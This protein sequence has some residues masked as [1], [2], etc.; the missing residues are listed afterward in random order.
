MNKQQRK[1]Y[2]K[3]LLS[4]EAFVPNTYV[5]ACVAEYGE[6]TYYLACDSP[7][8][9]A[10][11]HQHRDNGCKDAKAYTV[12]IN[13]EGHITGINENSTNWGNHDAFD[14][15]VQTNNGYVDAS[16]VKIELNGIYNLQWKTTWYGQTLSHYGD[17]RRS[18]PINV[19]MS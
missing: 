11:G 7:L 13:Q 5:A 3:P 4:S 1:T 18:T 16:V 14:I 15:K 17:F 10:D 9:G 6:T 8:N 12:Y 2:T 19:N